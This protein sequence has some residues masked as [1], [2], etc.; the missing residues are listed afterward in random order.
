MKKLICVLATLSLLLCVLPLTAL[1]AGDDPY[2]D[3]P[4]EG[5]ARDAVLKAKEYG[6]MNGRSGASFGT[7]ST[8]TRQEFVTVLAR[9]FG[10]EPVTDK[11]SFDDIS[12][13]W[14]R[15]NINAAVAHG[16]VD[17]GGKFRP[18]DAITR[19]EMAVMLVRALGLS[20]MAKLSLPL[21]FTDVTEDAG[22]IAVAY[23]I[24]M[25]NGTSATAFSPEGRALREQAA[26]MLVRVYERYIS[27]TEWTHA[28]Y[29]ISSHSQVELA[30]RFDAVSFGWSR[31][32][33]SG[34]EARLN[35]GAENANEYRVPDGYEEVVEELKAAGVTL[36]LS[37]FMN[38]AGGALSGLL[39]D[40][41]AREDAV[42]LILD[43]TRAL[44]L[45]GVTVDFEGL[46]A[47]SKSEFTAFVESLGAALKENAMTLYVTVMPTTADGAYYDG[48]DYRALGQSADRIILM[49][50][51]YA[52][53]SMPESLLGSEYYKNSALTPIA[54]VYRSLRDVTDPVTGVADPGKVSL[55]LSMSAMAWETDGA[56]K[57]ASTAPI[58]P[59]LSTV[60][61]RLS[62]PCQMGWSQSLKNPY[63]TYATE[64][65]QHI[66][67]WY[68]DQRSVDAK[69]DLARLLGVTSVSVWRLG[70]VPEYSDAGLYFN[71][72]ESVLG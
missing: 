22:Y 64:S 52:P 4:T 8:L 14:G 40:P 33:Y 15:G 6:L 1:A 32:E 24:D 18:D 42:G 56:G 53:L 62:G 60:Y 63:I 2:V 71:V 67:L 49:A 69:L 3:M 54:S 46:Y 57:L 66:F 47:K 55:N 50:H 21:P 37:V 12:T 45:S 34:G 19:R 41:A 31:M 23:D 7:G 11:N 35:T 58:Y 70:Q 5:W 36:H 20:D 65:G 48:Y 51:N 25:T 16:A 9:M 30:R 59:A 26:A 29:A 10:W 39:S 38:D 68:E 43:E 17:S 13:A 44:G 28:F 72:A 27:E 61:S